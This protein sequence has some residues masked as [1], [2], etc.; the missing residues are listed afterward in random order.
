MVIFQHWEVNCWSISKQNFPS[1][2]Y[3]ETYTMPMVIFIYHSGN[4]PYGLIQLYACV[5]LLDNF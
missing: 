3:D 5:V 2:S 1:I 4:L